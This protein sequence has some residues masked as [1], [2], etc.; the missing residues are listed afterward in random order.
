MLDDS[1]FRDVRIGEACDT[2]LK[3]ES[4]TAEDFSNSASL[5]LF[6]SAR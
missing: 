1:G 4:V 3:V 2:L 6:V 5:S